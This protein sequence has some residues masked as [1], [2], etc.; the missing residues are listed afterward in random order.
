MCVERTLL[1]AKAD[2]CVLCYGLKLSSQEHSC[3]IRDPHMPKSRGSAWS[4]AW[5]WAAAEKQLPSFCGA[6]KPNGCTKSSQTTSWLR[7]LL[8]LPHQHQS[9]QGLNQE[10]SPCYWTLLSSQETVKQSGV[11]S[12]LSA[13]PWEPG[14]GSTSSMSPPLPECSGASPALSQSFQKKS[15]IEKFYYGN[16]SHEISCQFD[17][18]VSKQIGRLQSQI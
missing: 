4:R 15:V 14:Q 13:L 1:S 18:I 17:L 16:L 6:E 5:P 3:A 7:E 12:S 10:C 9:R 11:A 2:R 8:Y